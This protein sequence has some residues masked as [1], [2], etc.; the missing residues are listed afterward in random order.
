V[1]ANALLADIPGRAFVFGEQVSPIP[2]KDISAALLSISPPSIP[3]GSAGGHFYSSYRKA[4]MQGRPSTFSAEKASAICVRL[5]Q[6]ESLTA[7]CKDEGMPSASTVLR[8]VGDNPEFSEQYATSRLI[9]YQMLAEQIVE[10]ADTPEI[11]IETKIKDD[12]ARE[13]TEGDM[14]GHRRLRVDTRK[15]MLSKM[16]PK[17][18]G[19]KLQ[20]EVTGNLKHDHTVGLSAETAELLAS[21][22]AGSGDPGHEAPVPD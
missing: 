15:W 17:I 9:G 16:L 19:D 22:K 4:D 2:A 12:G 7:I 5:S 13:T 1:T 10:I 18:Y 3:I 8:W 21:L 14:L 6:G 20:T 11:G